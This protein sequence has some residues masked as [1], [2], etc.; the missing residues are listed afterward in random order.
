M[1]A[2]ERNWPSELAEWVL[3]EDLF[4]YT[5]PDFKGADD[6]PGRQRTMR[7]RGLPDS[8]TG[9]NKELHAYCERFIRVIKAGF[10]KDKNICA[11]I[12]R[13]EDDESLLPIRLVAIHFDWPGRK[14]IQYETL[15]RGNLW[16]ELTSISKTQSNDD[17]AVPGKGGILRQRVARVLRISALASRAYSNSIS[18][19]AGPSAVLVALSRHARRR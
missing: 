2:S 12:F 6:S 13:E 10:G 19:Q 4:Q 14:P 3:I 11:T 16:H 18:H 5:L 1:P 8:R 17:S 7:G 9:I 15:S